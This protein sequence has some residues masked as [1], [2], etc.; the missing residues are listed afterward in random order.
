MDTIETIAWLAVLLS[1]LWVLLSWLLGRVAGFLWLALPIIG[2]STFYARGVTGGE[3]TPG[4][5]LLGPS[6]G[7][8]IAL[9]PGFI[10]VMIEEYLASEWR[11]SRALRRSLKQISAFIAEE[12]RSRNSRGYR[13]GLRCAEWCQRIASK[14][15]L[16]RAARS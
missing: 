16:D 15:A 8:G 7:L 13:A 6:I 4:S 1:T 9:I 12:N 2:F 3:W 5:L 10:R 14:Y 11:R